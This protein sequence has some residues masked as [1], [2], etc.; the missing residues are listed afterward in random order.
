MAASDPCQRPARLVQLEGDRGEI[1][2]LVLMSLALAGWVAA[3]VSFGGE[4]M[5]L[6]GALATGL[7]VA[8]MALVRPSPV[9]QS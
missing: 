1:G 5:W 6:F 2:T 3:A 7:T 4:R 8:A 9:E